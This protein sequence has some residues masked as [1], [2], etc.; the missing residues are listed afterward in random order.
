[1]RAMIHLLRQANVDLA[2]VSDEAAL[3]RAIQL[4]LSQTDYAPNSKLG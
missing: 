4:A 1:M 3:V 2:D